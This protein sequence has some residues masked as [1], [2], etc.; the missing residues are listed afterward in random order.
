VQRLPF[1]VLCCHDETEVCYVRHT[2]TSAVC[3]QLHSCVDL[4]LQPV[5]L[6]LQKRPQS[7]KN[8]S[9]TE[10]STET[11]EFELSIANP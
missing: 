4:L 3:R 7:T 11:D 6:L 9:E 1:I 10:S 8:T 5:L 2:N